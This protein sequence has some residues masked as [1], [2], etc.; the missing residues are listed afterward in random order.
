MSSSNLKP[1]K[2][3]LESN[4]ERFR[5]GP[6]ASLSNLEFDVIQTI[7]KVADNAMRNAARIALAFVPEYLGSGLSRRTETFQQLT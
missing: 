4:L 7:C 6:G 3:Q 5:M 2:D 1:S